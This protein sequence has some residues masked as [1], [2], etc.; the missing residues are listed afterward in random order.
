MNPE[1]YQHTRDL[2]YAAYSR[3][4]TERDAYLRE[5]CG[6]DEELLREVGSLLAADER[7]GDFLHKPALA[8]DAEARL[9][10]QHTALS[11]R[12]VAHYEISDLLGAG[13]MGEVWRAR[14]TRLDRHV[15]L[16]VLPL[17]FASD[18]NRLQRFT[19]EAKTA[20]AL[21]HQNIV[22]I[23]DIGEVLTK[24]GEL[25]YIAT[26]LI[27]GETLRQCLKARGKF[28]WREAIDIA[29][30]IAAAL[31]AAHR[32][33][34]VHRDI[35][36]ENVMLRSDGVVK[37]L[38]FGLAK[39]TEPPTADGQV[40]TMISGST[41]SG[42][43][44][45]TPRYMSPEQAR[46]EKV[47]VRTDIFSLGVLL[48]ELV[49]GQAPFASQT[50]GE[51]IAAILR[52]E[53][54]PLT[55]LVPTAPGDLERIVIRALR[56]DRADRFQIIGTLLSDLKELKQQFELQAKL[57]AILPS[58]HDRHSASSEGGTANVGRETSSLA[59]RAR[60]A[61]TGWFSRRRSSVLPV[62]NERDLIVLAD[63]ENQTGDSVFDGTLKQSLA[64]QLRQSPF[65]SLF[66][67]ERV[68]HTLR[69]MKRSPD[70]RITARIA[71]EICLRHNL[72]AF[73]AGSIAPLGSYYVITLEAIHGQTGFQLETEQVE[74]HSKEQVLRALSQAAV[75]LRAK[76]GES[77]HSIQQFDKELEETTTEKL[78]AFKAYSL[79]YEQTLNG[80]LID[81]IQLYR[82]A[83]ELDPDFS[84]AWSMLSIHHSVGG[85]PGL[86]AEYAEKAYLLK[87]RVSDY[88]QLQVT[89]RYHYNFTGDLHKALEAATLFKRIYP[90]TSTAPIDMLVAHDGLGQHEQAV[91]EGREAIQLNPN[92]APG[93]FY[94]GRSL[95]RANRLTEA[96]EVFRQAI[97]QKFDLL[98]IHAGLYQ[99]AYAAGDAAGMQQQL[100]WMHGKPEEFVALDWQA[101]AAACAGQGRQARELAR[102][103]IEVAA[104][105]DTKEM[106]AR[107]ALEQALRGV[108]LGDYAQAC[109]DAR[110]GLSFA[111]GR[112]SLPRAALALALC[113]AADEA[114]PLLDEMR[115]RFPT[116]TAIHA[117][118]LPTIGAALE[119]QRGNAAQALDHLHATL[120]YEGAAEFWPQ[121]LRGQAYL[122]LGRGAEA[123]AEFQKILDQR[124]HAPLSPL[125]PL[126]H[127]GLARAAKLTGAT[128]QCQQAYADFFT[129]WAAADA[130][131][132]LWLAA[133]RESAV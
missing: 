106:A 83:V 63:F 116:D 118:W 132:P 52:D 128:E 98:N 43:V 8:L 7:A 77:L 28:A 121:S 20:S 111:R 3:L 96:Q 126:A 55:Q 26:E 21:N 78:E 120:S 133:R 104:R 80:R 79:G 57:D 22:T 124:G 15:A 6:A 109:V 59:A 125:Y 31:D 13:G 108:A 122:Q 91:A 66:P 123:Q 102:R 41:D 47:D 51:S 4:P 95:V 27:E 61:M 99:I 82:R 46:G 11:G 50:M 48:Y 81:A 30:Q 64:I 74:A 35:K 101:G 75:R 112:A 89:F 86:A 103:A 93:Y 34:I 85:K 25:H 33:G 76:L 65:L 17:H 92:F 37:V 94:L 44:M 88:E 97:E 67:E 23:Y 19:R 12:C 115:Q 36:P 29:S 32:V 72:K 127:L 24:A 69:L 68:R 58:A 16:K 45:G 53:P 38:D 1:R 117:I 131:L 56:K 113:G 90:R 73:I 10:E 71:Q 18:A 119:L 40:S 129:A 70:E 107:F 105:G 5:Q 14:D 110:Q 42:V 62:L 100:D 130:D 9:H 49:T 54:P 60:Q 114:E 87:E 84:Y 2:Y 39:L